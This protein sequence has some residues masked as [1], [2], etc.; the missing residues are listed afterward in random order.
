MRFIAI[1]FFCSIILVS[2]KSQNLVKNPSFEIFEECPD[3]YTTE[4]S[5]KEL[6][7]NWIF[8]T[9]GTSDYFNSCSIFQVNVPNN[10]MGHMYAKDGQAYAGIILIQKSTEDSIKGKSTN[11]REYLQTELQEP[12]KKGKRY[13]V[14]FYYAIAT[15]STGAVNNIGAYISVDK[16]RSRKNK[17]LS[18]NPQ[19][20]ADS[21]NYNTEKDIWYEVVDTLLAKGGEKYLT[22]GNFYSDKNTKYEVLDDS[23]IRKS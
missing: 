21:I 22:I 5:E 20:K 11:Y 16:I 2:A 12:L 17:V 4:A 10:F 8:P 3:N 6:I 19:I 13:E 1:L 23:D 15:Y 9:R 14:K 7:P 18:F